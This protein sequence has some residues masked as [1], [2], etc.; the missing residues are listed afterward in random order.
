[1]P[2][3]LL[4]QGVMYLPPPSNVLVAVGWRTVQEWQTVTSGWQVDSWVANTSTNPWPYATMRIATQHNIAIADDAAWTNRPDWS[5]LNAEALSY[6]NLTWIYSPGHF[7][8]YSNF[9]NTPQ[10]I[11]SYY[12]G[13]ASSNSL[14]S[15]N[16]VDFMAATWY[17]TD[18]INAAGSSTNFPWR[19]VK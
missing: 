10:F 2:T 9:N 6:S 13:I 19:L 16:A 4:Y 17:L 12:K 3:S 5:A 1:M 14:T 8:S 18:F 15:S 7:L 11:I